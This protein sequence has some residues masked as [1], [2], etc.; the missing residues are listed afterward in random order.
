MTGPVW[1]IEANGAGNMILMCLLL[2]DLS[3]CVCMY[4]CECVCIKYGAGW[5]CCRLRLIGGK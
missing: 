4:V 5:F 1:Y 3:V 2:L